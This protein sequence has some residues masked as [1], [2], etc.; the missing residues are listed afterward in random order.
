MSNPTLFAANFQKHVRANAPYRTNTFLEQTELIIGSSSR[1]R[2]F[3][4]V[5]ENVGTD[6]T[7]SAGDFISVGHILDASQP[8]RSSGIMVRTLVNAV[9]DTSGFT[10]PAIFGFVQD[11]IELAANPVEF[12]VTEAAPAPDIRYAPL[13][14]KDGG[15][16]YSNVAIGNDEL[17]KSVILA[18]G[19]DSIAAPAVSTTLITHNLGITGY[20]VFL[21]SNDLSVVSYNTNGLVNGSEIGEIWSINETVNSFEVTKDSGFAVVFDWMVIA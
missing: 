13:I 7:L 1:L 12:L 21:Q 14:F 8:T 17:S 15:V 5:S 3:S 19:T 6:V 11:S 4:F 9:I 18:S 20:K 2:G 10:D 16:W